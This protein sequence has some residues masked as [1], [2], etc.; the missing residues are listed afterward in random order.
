MPL[1]GW[2]AA[3]AAAV[4]AGAAVGWWV[5]NRILVRQF[6]ARLARATEQL[7][8]QHAAT[9]DKLRSAHTRA[10][11]E[12]EQLRASLPRQIAA[13]STDARAKV[14]RLEEQLRFCHAELDRL[15][16]KP[17]VAEAPRRADLTDGF[18]PTQTLDTR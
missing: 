2:I 14:T 5:V 17:K 6:K 4:A 15:R 11:L 7:R 1:I 12:L 8:Q 16:P 13:A 3:V 18:A 10:Q 9:D